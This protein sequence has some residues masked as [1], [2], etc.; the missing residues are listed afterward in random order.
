VPRPG[1]ALLESLRFVLQTEP[2][3]P[4]APSLAAPDRVY[5]QCTYMQCTALIK[6]EKLVGLGPVKAAAL[7]GVTYSSY[8]QWR[9]GSRELPLYHQQH[10]KALRAMPEDVLEWY[11][12]NFFEEL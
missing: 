12:R 3:R 1:R 9:S 4:G 11:V 6:F 8:A 7:L 2:A 5:M 10:I